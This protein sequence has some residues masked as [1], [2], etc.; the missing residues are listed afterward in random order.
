[1]H[2]ESSNPLKTLANRT[3]LDCSRPSSYRVSKKKILAREAF[4][5]VD[6]PWLLRVARRDRFL[7]MF[8]L[9]TLKFAPLQ[10][11]QRFQRNLDFADWQ[12][13]SDFLDLAAGGSVSQ[14][15]LLACC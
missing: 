12:V 6:L 7:G 14:R 15:A 9:P 4:W 2:Y 1:M 11:M 10:V 5:S 8:Y 3:F 13:P